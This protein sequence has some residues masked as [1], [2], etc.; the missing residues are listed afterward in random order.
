[1]CEGATWRAEVGTAAKACHAM[2]RLQGM[3][4][5][6]DESEESCPHQDNDQSTGRSRR[7]MRLAKVERFDYCH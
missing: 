3:Y 7:D 6:G 1:M 5:G 2:A 4:S